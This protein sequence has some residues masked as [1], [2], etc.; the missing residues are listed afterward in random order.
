MSNII[1]KTKVSTNIHPLLF[2]LSQSYCG[3]TYDFYISEQ[4]IVLCKNVDFISTIIFNFTS[5]IYIGIDKI[6]L[7]ELCY[8][9]PICIVFIDIDTCGNV[10]E[11]EVAI[12]Y[13]DDI[14]II[15]TKLNCKLI[16]NVNV[17]LSNFTQCV[18]VIKFPEFK[19]NNNPLVIC[20]DNDKKYKI[21]TSL[22]ICTS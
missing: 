18:F 13:K 22:F 19:I 7:N 15:K 6:V 1:L 8:M 16:F 21:K 5:P 10:L 17:N 9:Y 12:L 2:H 20:N 4:E 14:K 11:K 3:T